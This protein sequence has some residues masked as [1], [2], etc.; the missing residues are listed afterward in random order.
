MASTAPSSSVKPMTFQVLDKIGG[1]FC[2]DEVLVRLLH[3]WEARNFKKGNVLMGVEVL[4]LDS[5]GNAVQG[6]ISAT[7]L[8]RHE[9]KLNRNSV[10]KLN[11]F[12]VKPAKTLYRVS[13]H[14][15]TIW[16]TDFTTMVPVLDGEPNIEAQKFRIPTTA[17][18]GTEVPENLRSKDRVF[19]HLLMQDGESI[20]VNLWGDIAAAFRQRWNTSTVQPTVLLITTVNPK[21]IGGAVT[22]SSTSSTRLYFDA[23][24][25]ET[26][27]FMTRF[28]PA[29]ESMPTVTTAITKYETVVSFYCIATVVDVLG[30][31]GWHYISCT[32][33]RCNTK[34][35]KTETSLYCT[36]C[37]KISNVGLTRYRFEI[38]VRDINGDVGCF[39]LFDDDGRDIAGRNAG[40]V[41]NDSIQSAAEEH[42]LEILTTTPECLKPIIGRTYKFQ[43]KLKDYNFTA[44]R[45]TFTVSRIVTEVAEVEKVDPSE[46]DGT[47]SAPETGKRGP[48]ESDGTHAAEE[49]G[50]NMGETASLETVDAGGSKKKEKRPRLDD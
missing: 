41:L 46:P 25:A 49:V 31:N 4:L 5:E 12:V 18:T 17:E 42:R 36:K 22:L 29:Q 48:S 30:Q 28:G 15:H 33:A 13:D 14:K 10:Y 26:Q 45:Q 1:Q 11:K 32:S 7:R 23:D 44:T 21:T 20:R 27:E 35:A 24:I 50:Q 39:V 8:F 19:L 16:F 34:L 40:D 6:F 38:S 2:N 3:F 37:R 43:I 47:L 9:G